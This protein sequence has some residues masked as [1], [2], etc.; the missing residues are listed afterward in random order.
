MPV[1]ARRLLLIGV[2]CTTPDT[3]TFARVVMRT[4]D[5]GALPLW[6]RTAVASPRIRFWGRGLSWWC[7]T[8]RRRGDVCG[9]AGRDS[10]AMPDCPRPHSDVD[11]ALHRA[12][13][14]W[15]C[16]RGRARRT[17]A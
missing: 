11:A 12:D 10:A 7:A 6:R 4:T 14:H 17:V 5:R 9:A 1:A 2:G 3:P 13:L 16:R 8:R 15:G